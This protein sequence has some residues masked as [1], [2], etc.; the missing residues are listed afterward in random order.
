M[1]KVFAT[2]YSTETT[3]A[4]VKAELDRMLGIKIGKIYWVTLTKLETYFNTY[5]SFL[6]TCKV[7]DSSVF[8]DKNI[9]PEGV[10][11]DWYKSYRLK[12]LP[13]NGSRTN[14]H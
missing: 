6:I 11:Y 13:D 5:N 10:V 8:M 12:N 4:D 7:P 9:W 14:N 2:K 3:E 1:A